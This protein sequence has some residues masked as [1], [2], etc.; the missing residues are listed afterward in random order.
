[1]KWQKPSLRLNT[2]ST[3][4]FS[5]LI[6]TTTKDFHLTIT[7]SGKAILTQKSAVIT[8]PPSTEHDKTKKRYV[9]PENNIYLLELGI[10]SAEGKVRSDKQDK[11]RQIN[12][13]VEIVETIVE[14]AGLPANFQIA[15]M[16]AG[17]GA[18]HFCLV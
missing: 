10:T 12:K 6:Y 11:F 8:A 2:C 1:M 13:Y 4:I 7:K 18:L 3:K 14:S 9:K 5:K 15:D 17:K 16:G